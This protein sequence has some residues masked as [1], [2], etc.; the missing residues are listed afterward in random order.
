LKNGTCC[1]SFRAWN[2]DQCIDGRNP[3]KDS[4][5]ISTY[6]C[7]LDSDLEVFF[8]PNID[9]KEELSL[10]VA[11]DEEKYCISL[12]ETA[13]SLIIISCELATKWRKRNAFVP[14]EYELL[15]S[16]LKWEI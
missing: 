2:T 12:D 3:K 15:K 10:V 9:N 13:S 14:L 6:T 4:S 7:D 8:Y 11:R 1:G 5:K 16:K